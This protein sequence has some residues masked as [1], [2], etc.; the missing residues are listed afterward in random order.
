[1]IKLILSDMDGTLLPFGAVTVSQRTHEAVLAAQQAG[2]HFGPAS[3]RD[4]AALLPAF[5]GD[6]RCV[7]TGIM[8]NGKQVFLNGELILRRSLP[9]DAMMRLGEALRPFTGSFAL[10]N[11]VSEDPHSPATS[12]ALG[13]GAADEAA[14]TNIAGARQSIAPVDELPADGAI[15]SA[16]I[17]VDT[18]F[19]AA[20]ELRL[21]AQEACPELAFPQPAPFFLDV[22]ER[23]WTKASALPALLDAM[24]VTPEEVA[25]FGDSENDLTMLEAVPDS[26]AVAN[27]TPEAAAAAHHH[28]GACEDDAVAQFIEDLLA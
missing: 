22:I 17:Y 6:Q 11:V 7:S 15:I 20:D 8:A 2:I 19:N 9:Q 14:R 12:Y 28:I 13:V 1:M 4:R 26:Y 24:G 5:Y 10:A 23:G 25:Y 27:A 21:I 16:G 3:G 18:H